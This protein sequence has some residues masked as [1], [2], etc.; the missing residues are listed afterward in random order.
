MSQRIIG[1]RSERVRGEEIIRGRG[2]NK[3]I[4]REIEIAWRIY[5]FLVGNLV[6]AIK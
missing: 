2:R 5:K 4:W 1:E 3:K 6:D